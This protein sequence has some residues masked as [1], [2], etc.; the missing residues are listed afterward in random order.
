MN[1]VDKVNIKSV[2]WE[3]TFPGAC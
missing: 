3:I 2:P 1:I